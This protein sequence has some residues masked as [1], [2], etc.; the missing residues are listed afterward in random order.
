MSMFPDPVLIVS[1]ALEFLTCTVFTLPALTLAVTLRLPRVPTLVMLVCVAVCSVPVRLVANTLPVPLT[2][3]APN[4]TLPPVM[5]AVA[6]INPPVSTL[7]P[8][9][10]PVPLTTP[11]PNMRLPPVTFEVALIR[12]PVNKLAPVTLPVAD[13]SLANTLPVPLTF[14]VPNNT[15]PPVMVP[16]A[17]ITPV[18][19]SPVVANTATFEVPPT[20]MA[21][22][23]P[24]L[25]TVTFEFP[26]LMFATLVITPERKAPLPKI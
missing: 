10:L 14:P 12:P 17:L 9:M 4:N 19:Y 26:L 22:L 24:A 21:M 13:M 3:P 5:F 16:V 7:P 6:L 18:T 15:L 23:P 25:S 20:P 11:D 1:A 2:T 8:V